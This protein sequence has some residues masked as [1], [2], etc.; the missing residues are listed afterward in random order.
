MAKL[1]YIMAGRD[2]SLSSLLI[3]EAKR[4]QRKVEAEGLGLTES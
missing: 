2:L 4:E 3:R 1:R